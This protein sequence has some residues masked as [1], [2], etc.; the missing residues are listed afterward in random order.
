MFNDNFY[1]TP[2]ELIEKMIDNEKCYG[3]D[4]VRILEPSAGKGNICDY[5][6]ND[7][8]CNRE[9]ID[10][11]EIEPEL[12][13][14]LFDKGY[15][16]VGSD[17]LNFKTFTEYNYIIANPPF[18]DGARHILKMLSIAESQETPCKIFTLCNAQ[19][20]KNPFSNE[21]KTLLKKLENHEIEIEFVEDAFLD[22]ERK[23]NVEV[24]ILRI[25]VNYNKE[26]KFFKI[27]DKIVERIKKYSKNK[28]EKDDNNIALS[29]NAISL[30]LD[31]IE[32]LIVLHQRQIKLLKEL[33][34]REN[35]Y[36]FFSDYIKKNNKD[37][38]FNTKSTNF[39][40]E[41]RNIRKYYWKEV[42]MF[43]E[44][45]KY[46]T[47]KAREELLNKIV[48]LKNLDF[49]K[50]NIE[51]MISILLTNGK[52]IL[53]ESLND[54]FDSI[55]KYHQAEFSKNIHYYTGWKSNSAFKINKKIII[56]YYGGSWADWYFSGSYK[57][58]ETLENLAHNI[59]VFLK[60]LEKTFKLAGL[61]SFGELI[62]LG[63]WTFENNL[64]KV[65]I[66]KKGTMHITF[67]ETK[68]LD[69]INFLVGQGKNWIP[70][71]EE[72]TKDKKAYEFVKENF[73]SVLINNQKALPI[74]DLIGA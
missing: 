51:M 58:E 60:D 37:F 30:P 73:E 12:Q 44:I 62:S 50:E 26:E 25:K 9:N 70:T 41:L 38:Y 19:T 68:I 71:N 8:R 29:N 67:K 27:F 65:K 43:P 1:P 17:F 72:I 47:L 39:N 54:F 46:L 66:Y 7:F 2:D 57:K 13:S 56:P 55:T 35:E 20:I 63:N 5:V 49:S 3:A 52:D 24:A 33:V 16:F 18:D 6:C 59:K 45:T 4:S 10:V 31:K 11:L 15:N 14:I 22:A 48:K 40:K 53:L 32:N 28:I 36:S 34:K 64:M 69:R 61:E 74:L 42:L 23:T 21:R